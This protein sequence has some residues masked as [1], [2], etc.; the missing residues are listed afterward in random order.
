M[1]TAN[2]T[3]YPTHEVADWDAITMDKSSAITMPI[4]A[5]YNQTFS[6]TTLDQL[7]SS[8]AFLVI[9]MNKLTGVVI[10]QIA[11]SFSQAVSL[12]HNQSLN[13]NIYTLTIASLGKPFTFYDRADGLPVV[14]YDRDAALPVV[15]YSGSYGID[16]FILRMLNLTSSYNRLTTGATQIVNASKAMSTINMDKSSGITQTMTA[17]FSYTVA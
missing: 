10:T 17:P 16:R 4:S 1:P 15:F 12:I 9:V 14:F 5:A 13:S 2:Q 7:T 8:N 11:S 3:L 6:S